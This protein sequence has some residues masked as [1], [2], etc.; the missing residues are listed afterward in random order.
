MGAK[1]GRKECRAPH[2]FTP[3]P[4]VQPAA[5]SLSCRLPQLP[6]NLC[7]SHPPSYLAPSTLQPW[8][9]PPTPVPRALYPTVAVVLAL[10]SPQSSVHPYLPHAPPPIPQAPTLSRLLTLQ[11]PLITH[12]CPAVRSA[13]TCASLSAKILK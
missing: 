6:V 1:Q 13:P 11:R 8:L 10:H 9:Q 5:C 7:C 4:D 2:A 12:L 3:P